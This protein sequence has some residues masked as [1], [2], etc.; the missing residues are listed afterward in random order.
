[1]IDSRGLTIKDLN[2]NVLFAAG[3]GIGVLNNVSLS[4]N[5]QVQVGAS[6]VTL[7]ALTANATPKWLDLKN[8]APGFGVDTQGNYTNQSN[9][10]LTANLYGMTGTATFAVTS[11]TATLTPT[12]DPNAKKL[13]FADML[14]DTV[15]ITATFVDSGTTYTDTVNLYKSYQANAVPLIVLTDE[16]ISL[17]ADSAGTVSSFSAATTT[18]TIWEGLNDVT[19][20]WTFTTAA[21]G[22]TITGTNTRTISV[23]AMSADSASVVFTATKSGKP[24]VTKTYRLTK[25]K[26][27]AAASIA[28]PENS[29][30]PISGVV[31]LRVAFAKSVA[32]PV[33]GKPALSA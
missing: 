11:G 10:L 32:I 8:N 27:G 3:L 2:G 21:T 12:T 24:T 22:C 14:T 6:N 33:T 29:K 25:A 28:V 15:G 18:A 23:T 1:M 31:A 20:Q 19:T 26:A 9:I 5:T 17:A 16:V 4:G 30:A 7:A 13:L